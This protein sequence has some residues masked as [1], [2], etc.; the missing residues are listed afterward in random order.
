MCSTSSPSSV[1]MAVLPVRRAWAPATAAAPRAACRPRLRP[2]PPELALLDEPPPLPAD[3]VRRSDGSENEPGPLACPGVLASAVMKLLTKFSICACDG[4]D[5]LA[6]AASAYE[7]WTA[8][9]ELEPLPPYAPEV[10][11]TQLTPQDR[12]EPH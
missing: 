11:T 4:P 3:R 10:P 1:R 9:H 6:P 2:P 5:A 12:R 8:S 7:S